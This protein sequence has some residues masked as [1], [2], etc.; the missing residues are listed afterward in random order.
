VKLRGVISGF[1]EV[2]A[3]GHLPG[4]L[5]RPDVSIVAVHD[6]VSERRHLAMRLANNVRVYDDLELMLA[7]E[8]PEFVDIASPPALHASAI[9]AA[10]EAGAHVLCEKPLCLRADE[11]KAL[12]E[13]AARGSRVLMCV[14]NWKHSPSYRRALELVASGR[15][16]ALTLLNIDRL[17]TQPAGGPGSWRAAAA[18]GGGILIDHGW[19]VS[20]LMQSLMHGDAPLAVSAHLG[21]SREGEV[22]DVA[23]LRVRF[24]G[25]R[26]ARSYMSWRA[27]VRR[28]S[29]SLYG[30][31]AALEIEGDRL[32]LTE[33]GGRT[34]ELSVVDAPD[35]SYHSAWFTGVAAEFERAI[36]E[37][38]GSAAA[39]R[40][41][42]EVST[43][44]RLI[45]AA[46]ESSARAGA[47]IALA[48]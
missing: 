1:G 12:A 10:L 42:T 16:G 15:L 20:Y 13:T 37:G 46:R 31:F 5:S 29:A 28:T 25:G 4:W 19:H 36:A 48:D 24:S 2:A 41:I 26:I 44:L 43:A 7:G 23:D 14:H 30:E 21:V 33:R 39:I 22:E 32:V 47:E 6:P 45:E 17:R 34:E 11:F 40:N 18:L 9:R 38:P 27:P 3:R 8:S 35:D